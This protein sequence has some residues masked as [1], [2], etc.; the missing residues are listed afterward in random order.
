[1]AKMKNIIDKKN[2]KTKKKMGG[3]QYQIISI[4]VLNMLEEEKRY[5]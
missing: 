3:Q 1:M 5:E 2:E 4:K